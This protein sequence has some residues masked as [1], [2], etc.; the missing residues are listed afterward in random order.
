MIRCRILNFKN[1]DFM[2]MVKKYSVCR[3][4]PRPVH[5]LDKFPHG[6]RFYSPYGKFNDIDAKNKQKS[7]I[8]L[9]REPG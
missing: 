8:L 2:L 4:A 9:V 6:K 5:V 3:F 1:F 7:A